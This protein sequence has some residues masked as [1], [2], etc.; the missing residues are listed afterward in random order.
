MLF[1]T[2]D[3]KERCALIYQNGN[4]VETWNGLSLTQTWSYAP[5]LQHIPV[6]YAQLWA[7]GKT[8]EEACPAPLYANFKIIE[9]KM[10]A[11]INSCYEAKLNLDD[12]CF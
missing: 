5:Y 1:Q 4:L 3:D 10:K 6:E 2:F 11:F 9:K 7:R 8:L 12:V